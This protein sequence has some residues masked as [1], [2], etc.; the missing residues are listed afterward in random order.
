VIALEMNDFDAFR[1]FLHDW[2]KELKQHAIVQS[3]MMLYQLFH[4]FLLILVPLLNQVNSKL[5]HFLRHEMAIVLT[6]LSSPG[7]AVTFFSIMDEFEANLQQFTVAQGENLEQNKVI[8]IVKEYIGKN[9]GDKELKLES[10]SKI[11]HMNPNY[12]SDLF[13]EVTG[14]NYIA[15][16]TRVRMRRAK[17][18]LRETHL[19]TYEISDQVGYTTAKYFCKLFRQLFGITPTEYR[20]RAEYSME[21]EIV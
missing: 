18:L 21:P 12:L 10:L 5:S 11:V 14:E 6:K 8:E 17:K 16:L 4:F 3:P 9:F 15:Y 7:T 20:N 2:F 13:K 1:Q 19:K